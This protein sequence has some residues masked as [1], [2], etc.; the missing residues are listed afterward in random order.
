MSPTEITMPDRIRCSVQ[1]PMMSLARSPAIPRIGSA[2]KGCT[3][4]VQAS[5]Q[6][7]A[8]AARAGSTPSACAAGRITGACTAHWPPPEGTKKFTMPALMKDQKGRL[9]G[10]ASETSA[11][12]IVAARPELTMIAMMP[13]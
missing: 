13:A 5:P 1:K 6:A 12:E 11:S 3:M 10:V 2:Q 8:I 4:L 7:I 9:A